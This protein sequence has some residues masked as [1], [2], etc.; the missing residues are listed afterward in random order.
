MPKEAWEVLA[1]HFS[2]KNDMRLQLLENELM[3]TSKREFSINQYFTKVKSLCREMYE[4]DP[5]A[6]INE[7]RIRT[8]I[9]HG[10]R[11]EYR[12]FMAAV[13]GWQTQPSL[14]ELENLL[15]NEEILTKQLA[16][17]TLKNEEE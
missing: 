2:K 10:R 13:Q 3:T 6:K 15:A 9:A 4:L 7:Q 12:G 5:Y 1:I 16:N 14:E 17:I 8:I 11:P